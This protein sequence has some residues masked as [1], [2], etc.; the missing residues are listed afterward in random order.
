[1]RGVGVWFVSLSLYVFEFLGGGEG[2]KF[3]SMFFFFFLRS[4]CFRFGG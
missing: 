4:C 1:M 3:L 2:R